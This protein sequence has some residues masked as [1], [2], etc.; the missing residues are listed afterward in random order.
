MK[1][2]IFVSFAM[3]DET[4]KL[5]FCGQAKN[6]RVP[7]EFVDMSVKKPWDSSWKTNCKTRIKGCDAM[8]VLISENTRNA[9]GAIWEINCAKEL[10]LRVRGIY[11]KNGNINNKPSE[12]YGILSEAWTWE[13][14][15]NFIESI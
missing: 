12:M 8:I 5:L 9:D 3:E 7:Y 2:R 15:K 14:V 11:I 6:T 1:K 10:G 4:S 13:N